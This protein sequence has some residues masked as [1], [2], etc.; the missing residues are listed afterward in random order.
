MQV[1]P[2]RDDLKKRKIL[3]VNP[4]WT[5]AIEKDCTV[6]SDNGNA[7]KDDGVDIFDALGFKL[8]RSFP[9]AVH[10][11]LSPNDNRLHGAA[12]KA[13]IEAMV[14][15]SDDVLAWCYLTNHLDWCNKDVC[16]WFDVNLQLKEE[17]P[18]L[19]RVEALIK[20]ERVGVLQGVPERVSHLYGLGCMRRRACH[21]QGL[22]ENIVK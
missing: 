15:F 9:A 6:L 7:F 2:K 21:S 16:G 3:Y 5:Y 8:H 18:T 10:Q 19:K 11:Y 4:S 14:D 17:K 12:K 1:R 22:P 20:G 13:W